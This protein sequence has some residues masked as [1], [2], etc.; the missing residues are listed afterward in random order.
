MTPCIKCN[1]ECCRYVTVN[2]DTPK[3]KEDWDEIKWMLMHDNIMVYQETDND[4]AVEFLTK[5]KH[6]DV[7]TNKCK[8]YDKRPKV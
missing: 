7:K 5:C 8:I 2:I 3:D 1:A 4:W 6:V